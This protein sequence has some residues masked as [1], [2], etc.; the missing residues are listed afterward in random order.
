MTSRE[1]VRRALNHQEPDRVP[2]DCGSSYVTGICVDAYAPLAHSLGLRSHPKV[3]EP[4]QMLAEVA[5]E[6]M[7]R[8][9][10]DVVSLP[11]LVGMFGTR[12]EN[13]KPFTTF[14]GNDVLV[15]GT[16]NPVQLPNGDLVL[17][18]GGDRSLPPSARMPRGGFYF[19]IIVRQKP[20]IEDQLRPEE[21]AEQFQPLTD[22]ELDYLRKAS[23]RLY[24]ETDYAIL[25]GFYSGGL[26]DYVIVAAPGLRDPKGVR[27]PAE[28]I[29]SHLTRP[30]YIR[31]VFELQTARALENLQLY[32]QAVG[33]R[34]EAIVISGTD[35]GT[36]RV[37]MISP[38]IYR[39]LYLP[40][41][42]KMNDWVHHHTSWKT[43][44]HS[45]GSIPRI[46]P[47][48][49]EAGVDILNPVQC[50]AQGM[51]PQWLKEQFGNQ[52]TFWGGAVDTQ[53]TLPFGTPE[54]VAAEVAERIRIFAPGGGF[55][56][57]AIHNIQQGT[58]PQNILAM[59]DAAR[60]R[61]VYPIA[62]G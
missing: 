17:S 9:G 15:P 52:L 59:F 40:F 13:W 24:R 4:F 7:E 39:E 10:C 12:N 60:A 14:A 33:D 34:I 44:Y 54:E 42:K 28:W 57:N 19:D 32:R 30:H 21:F 48:M 6:V 36:Q 43:F 50:S 49:I 20:I 51:A 62:T 41:H 61:G 16:F 23:E 18:P 8:L 53:K 5:P 27:D 25:G 11:P 29:I 35:F 46:I 55:V 26:G 37:E 2:V 45:C 22:E 31:E 58:P 56:I 1:R 38:D 47:L 3:T